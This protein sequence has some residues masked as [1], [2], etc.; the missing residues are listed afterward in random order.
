M[1]LYASTINTLIEYP[2]VTGLDM[3]IIIIIITQAI[4]ISILSYNCTAYTSFLPLVSR[5]HVQVVYTLSY[6]LMYCI[7]T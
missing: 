7:G 3:Y 5:R 6:P 2:A 1:R 4:V